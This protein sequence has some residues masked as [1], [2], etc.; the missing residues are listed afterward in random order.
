MRLQEPREAAGFEI[1]VKE[2]VP[3]KEKERG[4]KER[5]VEGTLW[6]IESSPS[7]GGTLG[8]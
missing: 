1:R 2:S 7:Q 3:E 6:I 5:D 8:N 4:M